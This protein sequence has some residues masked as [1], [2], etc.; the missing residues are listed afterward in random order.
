LNDPGE[1]V[2]LLGKEH[3]LT[4]RLWKSPVRKDRRRKRQW[5]KFTLEILVR[6]MGKIWA[7][8]LR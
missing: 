7:G 1:G 8:A 5:G 3:P 2:E 4:E 6:D